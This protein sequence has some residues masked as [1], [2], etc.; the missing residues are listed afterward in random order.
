MKYIPPAATQ[1]QLR[2]A[3][4]R[5]H[6]LKDDARARIK[7]MAGLA[8][9]AEMSMKLS[10]LCGMLYQTPWPCEWG[11][12]TPCRDR[13]DGICPT[14]L[15]KRNIESTT[16]YLAEQID[17][18]IIQLTGQSLLDPNTFSALGRIKRIYV[19][20]EVLP[21]D[22]PVVDAMVGAIKDAVGC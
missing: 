11:A 5:R 14:C 4:Q 20:N 3:E 21:T 10:H 6:V 16:E 13:I 1:V 19:D 15:Q 7:A 22:S 8:A 18:H 2:K 9:I 12:D 17:K